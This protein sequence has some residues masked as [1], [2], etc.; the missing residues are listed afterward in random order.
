MTNKKLCERIKFL[1]N[2]LKL[3]LT[4]THNENIISDQLQ[5]KTHKTSHVV[6]LTSNIVV[7]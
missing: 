7:S 3:D 1:K 2:N 4:H 6:N 5:T